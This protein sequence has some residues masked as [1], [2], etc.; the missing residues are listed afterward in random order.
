M[1]A[2]S[3]RGLKHKLY[4]RNKSNERLTTK[5]PYQ[6]KSIAWP[7]QYSFQSNR[8]LSKYLIMCW[9]AS[10]LGVS[11]YW[12]SSN[13]VDP[14]LFVCQQI[15]CTHSPYKHTLHKVSEKLCNEN[16][17]FLEHTH[18]HI[19]GYKTNLQIQGKTSCN[20]GIA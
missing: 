7:S 6:S 5:Y 2:L 11:C 14:N 3:V 10:P 13:P 12:D 19:L 16:T 15:C 20:H 4:K 18:P 9:I 8:Y 17:I 1:L